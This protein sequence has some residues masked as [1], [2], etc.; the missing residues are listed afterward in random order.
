MVSGNPLQDLRASAKA[1]QLEVL[2]F[3]K[4]PV[5]LAHLVSLITS[6]AR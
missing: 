2:E 3:L 6:L 1:Q 4:K 5:S